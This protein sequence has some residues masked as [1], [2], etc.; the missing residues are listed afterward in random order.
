[1]LTIT[2]GAFPGIFGP[3]SS[4][5]TIYTPTYVQPVGSAKGPYSLYTGADGNNDRIT[6]YNSYLGSPYIEVVPDIYDGGNSPANG[7]APRICTS[8]IGVGYSFDAGCSIWQASGVYGTREVIQGTSD[9]FKAPYMFQEGKTQDPI[10]VWVDEGQRSVEFLYSEDITFK[11]IKLWRYLM[12]ENVLKNTTTSSD[13]DMA[14]HYYMIN[15]PSGVTSRQRTDSIDLFLSKPHYLDGDVNF[16]KS[17]MDIN[18]NPTVAAHQ[19]Y[20]DVEPLSGRVFA[21][22]KRL[23][24]GSYLSK[25]RTTSFAFGGIYGP[26]VSQY[27]GNN[28][29]VESTCNSP[30][31]AP[32]TQCTYPA[33][34]S[35]G[36]NLYWP[37][38]WAVEGKDISDSDAS[39][40]VSAVYGTRQTFFITQIVLVI[41]GGVMFFTFLILCVKA[42]QASTSL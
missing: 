23:Q 33:W 25:V 12:T 4:D 41:V 31:G 5:P 28:A 32:A 11:N 34:G 2:N 17:Q 22:R 10:I 6:F 27:P 30:A 36:N 9:G 38:A 24:L 35:G 26:I 37:I 1:L 14:K 29:T 39:S 42:R 40:F 3:N 19:T 20:L 13:P 18:I 15:H 8:S 21:G 7:N 16:H